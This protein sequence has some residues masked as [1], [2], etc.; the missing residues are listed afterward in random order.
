[1]LICSKSNYKHI[2]EG[3]NLQRS[4]FSQ[5]KLV[6]FFVNTKNKENKF[7]FFTS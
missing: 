6:K 4:P 7:S 2:S 3:K 5:T 1:M